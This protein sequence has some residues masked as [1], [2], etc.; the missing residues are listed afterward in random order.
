MKN[1]ETKHLSLRINDEMLKKFRYVCEYAGRSANSQMLVY[2]RN[3]IQ[4]FEETHGEIKTS[5]EE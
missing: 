3:A 2:I 1:N 4:R 5:E